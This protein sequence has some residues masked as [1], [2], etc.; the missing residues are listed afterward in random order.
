MHTVGGDVLGGPAW[1]PDQAM[2]DEGGT[3]PC[4]QCLLTALSARSSISVS[5]PGP[6]VGASTA[7]THQPGHDLAGVPG[8]GAGPGDFPSVSHQ[9]RVSCDPQRPC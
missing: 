4:A 8:L 1:G 5:R 7:G 3:Q 2:A 9:A 6:E